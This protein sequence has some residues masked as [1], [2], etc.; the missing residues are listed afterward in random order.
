MSQFVTREHEIEPVPGLPG[1]P[2]AGEII[3]WQGRPSA[4]LLSRHLLKVRWIGGYFAALAV[5]AV[6]S[7]LHDGREIGGMLFS[8][9]ILAALAAVLIGMIELFAWAVEK[10]TLYTITTE[11]VVMRFGVALSMT[12]N[13]PFR[14]ITA[15]STAKLGGKGGMIAIAVSP[16]TRLSWLIQWPHVRGWR[17]SRPEPSLVYLPDV[18]KAATVLSTAFVQ[19]RASHANQPR[20]SVA[21]SMPSAPAA[22]AAE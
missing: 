6:V 4:K 14:Q 18:E 13:L 11:R 1:L 19:F 8:V 12:L 7:G 21:P 10:T 9:A 15:V 17:F 20:I 2:P 16:E 5:W 3:L 22:V